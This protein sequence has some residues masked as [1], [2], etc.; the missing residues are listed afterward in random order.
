MKADETNKMLSDKSFLDKL[1]GFAY[2]RCSTSHDA[3]DLCSDIILAI[4]RSVQRGKS[5]DNF[6]AFARTV[7]HHVYA[8][9]CE[10]HIQTPVLALNTRLI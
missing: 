9:F 8:D 4:L 7:A 5:I 10:K 3:E 1:Y 2:K 6:Y